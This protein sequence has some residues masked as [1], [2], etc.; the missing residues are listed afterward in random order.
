[1]KKVL[2]KEDF[3]IPGTK[4]VL[5]EGDTIRIL[6]EADDFEDLAS[7]VKSGGSV[8]FQ[9]VSNSKKTALVDLNKNNF[10]NFIKVFKPVIK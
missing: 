6:N 7:I 3:Q 1:M 2:I 9:V 5:E 4:L 10:E 8:K